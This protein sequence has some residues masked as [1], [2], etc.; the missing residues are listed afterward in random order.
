MTLTDFLLLL[1]VAGLIGAIGQG[2]VGYSHG[3]CLVSIGVGF[4]GA[5]VGTWLAKKMGL[6]DFFVL[7]IGTTSLPVV[8]SI[9]GSAIFIALISLM[10][11]FRD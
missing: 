9:A 6:P 3:G 11:R 2:I 1:A 7:H 8:W 4:I 10:S 5:L